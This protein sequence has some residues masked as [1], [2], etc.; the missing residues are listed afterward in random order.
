MIWYG[1]D[2]EK[3]TS[4]HLRDPDALSGGIFRLHKE[5]LRH[6]QFEVEDNT[7]RKL[8]QFGS[9]RRLQKIMSKIS[10]MIPRSCH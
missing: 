10:A 2:T 1:D 7:V 4:A 8:E 9:P 6:W 5:L 3:D